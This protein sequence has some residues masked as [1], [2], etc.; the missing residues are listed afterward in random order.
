MNEEQLRQAVQICIEE[1]VGR[2]SDFEGIDVDTLT[3]WR[4]Q[5]AL[6]FGGK[7]WRKGNGFKVS[8]YSE[9]ETESRRAMIAK[10]NERL[11]LIEVE[12]IE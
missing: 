6:G 9:D 4:F 7:L 3:E 1:C 11:A 5:G 12:G 10:A 8:C 2:E